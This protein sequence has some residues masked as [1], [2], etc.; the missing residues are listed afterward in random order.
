[1]EYE[2]SSQNLSKKSKDSNCSEYQLLAVI[3]Q[4][5]SSRELKNSKGSG[6]RRQRSNDLVLRNKKIVVSDT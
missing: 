6:S 3:D 1:M 4:R 2:L 5:D